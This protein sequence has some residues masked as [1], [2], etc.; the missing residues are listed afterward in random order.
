MTPACFAS[1]HLGTRL[2]RPPVALDRLWLGRCKARA[3]GSSFGWAPSVGGVAWPQLEN[4]WP[5][6]L[7]VFPKE[8]CDWSGGRPGTA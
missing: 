3:P 6:E 2:Q 5:A 4:D 1:I 8:H 7:N